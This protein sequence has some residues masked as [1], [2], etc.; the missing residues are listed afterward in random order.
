MALQPQTKEWLTELCKESYSYQEVLSKTGRAKSD[1]NIVTL[2]KKVEE[3]GID[4]S[5]FNKITSWNKGRKLPANTPKYELED[6]FIKD[7]PASRGTIKKY[8]LRNE[9][10]EYKCQMCGCDGNWQ[11]KILSLELDHIDGDNTNNELP[12]LRW[13]CPNCHATTDTYAGKNAKNRHSEVNHCID[14]GVEIKKSSTRCVKCNHIATRKY[15]RPSREELKNI[16]RELS[17]SEAGRCFGVDGKTIS[18][19]CKN[20]NL[21][22]RKSEIKSYSD[23]EWDK[24]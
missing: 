8:I 5:H 21:P 19:W 2:K 13:L 12:N 3:F 14:C 1:N 17:F 22:Y 16:V 7:S 9:L 10:L 15:N 18:R 23:E 20:E 11:G 6:I 24:I 4:V